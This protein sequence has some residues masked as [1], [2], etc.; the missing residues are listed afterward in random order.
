MRFHCLELNLDFN[1]AKLA[2][3]LKSCG[4]TIIVRKFIPAVVEKYNIL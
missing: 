4:L 1:S 3:T 2:Y